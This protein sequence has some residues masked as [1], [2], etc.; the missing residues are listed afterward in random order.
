MN[1]KKRME[2]LENLINKANYE[3]HTLDNPTI[4]DYLYDSYLKEL[5]EL[6]EEYPQ[7]KSLNSPTLKIGGVVLD[8]F[9]KYNHNF[10]MMSLSNVF[11][12]EELKAFDER[13]KKEVNEY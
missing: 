9:E 1:I 6:E 4:S 7:Y 10:P 11:N 8:K 5:I 12:E 13:I 3:Y 2:E